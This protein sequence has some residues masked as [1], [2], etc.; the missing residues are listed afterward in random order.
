MDLTEKEQQEVPLQAF[1]IFLHERPGGPIELVSIEAAGFDHVVDSE[2]RIAFT[3]SDGKEIKEI[4]CR[5]ASVALIV[6]DSRIARSHVFVRLEKKVADLADRL[7]RIEKSQV[8]SQ[9]P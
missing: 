7:D 3:D 8:P 2:E 4:F 9:S 1:H 6:P 5:A